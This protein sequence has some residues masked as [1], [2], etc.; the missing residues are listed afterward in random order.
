MAAQRS[1][2]G[3]ANALKG[4]LTA[5]LEESTSAPA[6]AVYDLLADV[7]SHLEWAGTRQ[8]K[9]SYRLLSIE[10]PEGPAGVGTE[11][12]STGADA[13]GRFADSSVVTE[14]SR[15][16]LFEF[17]TEAR[18]T[19]KRDVV[20]EW[21][22]VHRYEIK[23]EGSGCRIVYD[24]RIV[25]LSPT[26]GALALFTMPGLRSVLMRIGASYSRKGLRN[27]V[28]MAEERSRMSRAAALEG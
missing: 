9:K 23:P 3:R 5:R 24:V 13:M 27:L 1:G 17:V 25:R 16:G 19:T 7:G 4:E 10:G 15:P 8:P 26:P 12:T 21:T 18:L 28:R 11:F 22:L 20:V 14:A 6:E 2:G